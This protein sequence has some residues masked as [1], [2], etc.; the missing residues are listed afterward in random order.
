LYDMIQ[1]SAW[2][3]GISLI[4]GIG[5]TGSENLSRKNWIDVNP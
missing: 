1:L 2:G 4:Y 5:K 3:P